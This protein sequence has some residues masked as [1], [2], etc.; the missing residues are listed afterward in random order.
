MRTLLFFFVAL[1]ISGCASLHFD[2]VA[3]GTLK[4]KLVVEWIEPDQFIF[5]PDT[6][7]P[8]TFTRASGQ[9]I[10][11]GE[12]L[13]DGGSIPR[14]LWA[15]RS[16]SPWG[17]APAFIVHDWLFEMKHCQYLG[18]DKFTVDEAALIMS[19]VMKTMMLD[20]KRGSVDELT[21]YA[22]YEAVK[23]PI[24]RNAWDQGKCSPPPRGFDEK[25]LPKAKMRY[26]I[27]FP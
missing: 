19:E 1:Q 16:Y 10:T 4:G 25:T 20:P 6:A 13:T 2:S 9:S 8:L 26:T 22:M 12:M 23:S 17:Y 5:R 11:P 7:K 24:A 27:E 14:P 18:Y 3:P 21:L 15:I